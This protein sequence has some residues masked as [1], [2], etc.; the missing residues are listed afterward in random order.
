MYAVK[1]SI[2]VNT[3]IIKHIDSN[4]ITL[5]IWVFTKRIGFI[6]FITLQKYE[7]V[8]KRNYKWISVT[9]II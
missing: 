3:I 9:Q 7:Y 6:S 1:D 8:Y 5:I 2:S 4:V